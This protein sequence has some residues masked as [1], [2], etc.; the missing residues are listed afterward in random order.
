MAAVPGRQS[1]AEPVAS[2]SSSI[3]CWP[4]ALLQLFLHGLD[5]LF[6]IPISPCANLLSGSAVAEQAEINKRIIR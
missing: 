5:F 4:L 1:V 3:A 6:E 2:G